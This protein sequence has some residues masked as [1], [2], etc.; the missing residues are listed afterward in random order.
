MKQVTG[1][2]RVRPHW[3]EG[4]LS[5]WLDA[6]ADWVNAQGYAPYTAYRKILLAARFSQWLR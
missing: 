5:T 6:F 2:Q 4:P 1:N 3:R